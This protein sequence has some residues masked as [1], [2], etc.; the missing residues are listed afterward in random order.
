[1]RQ[2]RPGLVEDGR[3]AGSRRDDSELAEG[4]SLEAMQMAITAQSSLRTRQ[5]VM[6]C[7]CGLP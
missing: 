6:P 4:A 5:Q 1:M 2:A 7:D 3:S